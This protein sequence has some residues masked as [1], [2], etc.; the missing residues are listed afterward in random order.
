[1]AKKI[2]VIGY[3]GDKFTTSTIDVTRETTKYYYLDDT[4]WGLDFDFILK[5]TDEGWNWTTD[6][7]KFPEIQQNY[8][9]STINFKRNQITE[10]QDALA[11]LI[12][13]AKRLGLKV[14]E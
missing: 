12:E 8:V 5:K 1:M 9:N 2:Y 4:C 13:N 10:A 6:K 11:R 7:A 3:F 14:E